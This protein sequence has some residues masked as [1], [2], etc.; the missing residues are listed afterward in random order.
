MVGPRLIDDTFSAGLAQWA[1]GEDLNAAL[2]R[3][4][5]DLYAAKRGARTEMPGGG[6]GAGTGIAERGFK[7]CLYKPLKELPP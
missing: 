4:A 2:K 1:H 6:S 5:V 7:R 3:E